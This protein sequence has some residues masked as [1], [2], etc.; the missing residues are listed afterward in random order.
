[1]KAFIIKSNLY[2]IKRFY[3]ILNLQIIK[4]SI[5]LRNQKIDNLFFFKIACKKFYQKEIKHK[6]KDSKKAI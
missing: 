3:L 4:F 6:F 1:M 5:Q 2:K